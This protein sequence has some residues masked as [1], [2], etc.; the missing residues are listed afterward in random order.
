MSVADFIGRRH[1]PL[2]IGRP[3][4]IERYGLIQ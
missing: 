2:P 1:E 4:L 3:M